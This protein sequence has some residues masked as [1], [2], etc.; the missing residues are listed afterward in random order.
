MPI[1]GTLFEYDSWFTYI[2][3]KYI[4]NVDNAGP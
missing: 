3:K 4:S 2:R 1:Q